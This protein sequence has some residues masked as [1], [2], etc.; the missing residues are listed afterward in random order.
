MRVNCIING[1]NRSFDVDASMRLRELLELNGNIAVRDSDDNEGFCGSDTVLVDG[2]PVYANLVLAGEV[3]G[4]EIRTPDGLADSRHLTVIQQAMIDAGVVQSAYNAPAAAL[5]LTWLLENNPNPSKEEIKDALSG[6]FIRDAGY[7]H[8]YLA[9]KLAREKMESGEYRTAPAPSF[10][11]NLK[12][13]GKPASKIDGPQLV[14]GEKAFV[15]DFVDPHS[16]YMV[17]LRSPHASAYINSIDTSEAEKV[18]GVVKILTAYNTPDT[19]YMQAGQGNPEPSPHDRRLFNLKVRHV[20]DRVAAVIAETKEAAEQARDL[21]KVSYEVLPAVFTVEEAMAEGAPLVH[22]GIVEYRS[23][24]PADLDEYNS[25]AG[26]PREGKVIYQFPLHADIHKNIAASNKGGIG[27]IDKAFR[28]ADAVVEHTYQTSQIQH[29]P[30]EP[31]V[32]FAKMEAGRLVV[33]ASTQVPYHVRRIV[34]WVTGLPENKI[35]VIKTRVGGGYG[36]KQDI[37]VEDLVGYASYVTGKPIYYR[38]TREEEFIA[39]STRHPM[40]VHVKMSGKKDGTIT[41][42]FM[43]VCANTGPYGNHCLTVP[44]NSC[45]KTL[46]LFKCD[47]MYYDLK[48]YYTNTPPAGAYQGYGTPKGTYGLMMA[49]AELSEALGCDY[50]EMVLKNHVE[51]GYMLEILKGLGEGRE[52]N[53]VPVGSCGLREAVLKGC[54][55][56]QWGKKEVSDDPDWKIGKG[57]AMIMQGSGLPGLDHSEAIAKLE[58]DGTVILN[59]GGAD[60]GTGLDTISAKICSEV[61]CMPLEKITVVSGDTDSCAFD[62]GAYASSGTFFSGNASLEAAK[63]LK[64]MI[65]KEAAFQLGEKEEDMFLVEPGAVKSKATGKVLTYA[66][67]SHTACSGT[68]HG[69]MIAHGN[70]VTAASSVPY[71]AHFAQVAV[72]VRTGEIKVQKFYALQDA[73]TPINPEIALC[74]M[75]GAVMKS[76]G[77]SLYEDMKLDKNG[78]CINANMTDYGV[79]M[80]TE[81]PEDFKSV[82]ID[83]NDDYGPFGA[84]SISEIA[85]NGAAPAIGMAIHDACGVWLRDWPMTPEKILKGLGKI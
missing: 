26:D 6:I 64:S 49:M 18:E 73:G 75:Y 41:G 85:C 72:N 50:K 10:R 21:I 60:L 9:V 78:K 19:H 38:N 74:Q 55:M 30:L 76:I 77:H 71:G 40:R 17:V 5:L 43:E 84:K 13:V 35:H 36:S 82:L 33:V 14:A 3:E 70:F 29:T 25:K 53:V 2:V 67:L 15:E 42:I 47:N 62:T 39:N 12:I 63:L 56:I 7:E 52:G 20:G 34:G 79:P 1:K 81:A 68:G 57:F 24:A 4:C 22:N 44:M 27:D 69:Q 48:V 31:H 51:E 46:P 45:S 59:S 16:C 37:L 80:I 66:E 28:E 11:E 54:D 65:L 8:Y 83:V 61:L 23:G 58:T 32:C